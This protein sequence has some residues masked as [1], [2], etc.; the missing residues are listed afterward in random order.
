MKKLLLLLLLLPTFSFGQTLSI[1]LNGGAALYA[2]MQSDRIYY[3]RTLKT[4]VYSSLS[5]GLRLKKYELVL[6]VA[7]NPIEGEY[8]NFY[9]NNMVYAQNPIQ[10]LL[11]GNYHKQ[12][13]DFD[14]YGGVS[15]GIITYKNPDVY[16]LAELYPTA[17]FASSS[18][19]GSIA[20]IQVGCNYTIS[21]RMDINV[22]A[23]GQYVAIQA[24]NNYLAYTS[25]M[26]AFKY[27]Y[28]FFSFPVSVGVK[29]KFGQ[30]ARRRKG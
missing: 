25:S 9:L 3:N 11:Q 7:G 27:H 4:E 2:G 22:E 10:I 21:R 19:N 24:E 29:Y 23:E 18:G 20:G 1:G 14:L 5:M 15:A 30:D 13:G 12:L 17:E 26:P 6:R 28:S 16:S 8:H